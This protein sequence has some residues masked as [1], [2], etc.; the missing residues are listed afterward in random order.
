MPSEGVGTN[1]TK[2]VNI[3]FPSSPDV[4]QCV[5]IESEDPTPL[6]ISGISLRGVSY[7]GE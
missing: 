6:N 7:S 3:D 1:T 2:I 5:Y 4:E